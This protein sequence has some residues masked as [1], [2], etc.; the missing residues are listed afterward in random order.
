MFFFKYDSITTGPIQNN[1]GGGGKIEEKWLNLAKISMKILKELGTKFWASKIS[2]P[3]VVDWGLGFFN[4]GYP[5]G[6]D[7]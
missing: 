4:T 7:F 6:G 1:M 2:C 5:V 3:E